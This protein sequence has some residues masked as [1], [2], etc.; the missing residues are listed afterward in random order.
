M[1]QVDNTGSLEDLLVVLSDGDQG[2]LLFD[3]QLAA[4]A[5]NIIKASGDFSEYAIFKGRNQ[6]VKSY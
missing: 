3:S 4:T 1:L 5:A 2:A 6:M